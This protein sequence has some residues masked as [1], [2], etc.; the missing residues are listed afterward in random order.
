MESRALETLQTILGRRG[1][2]TNVTHIGDH[3]YT[4]GDQTVLFLEGANPSKTAI[5]KTLE[6]H[7]KNFILVL[8]AP[9]S[10]SI[11]AHMRT[12]ASEPI[13]LF[14]LE[15]LQFDIMSHKKY[16]FPCRIL[17]PDQKANL[18]QTLR[19]TGYRQI[20]RI[21]YDDPYA[22]YLGAKPE[23]VIE[24]DIPSEAAG[25]SKS[26]SYVVTNIEEV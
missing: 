15:Q 25:W 8:S 11:R 14:H 5:D 23:D 3:T 19:I 16:G 10:E 2:Q 9:P 22:L 26:Y 7:P 21:G 1:L 6:E 13:Q 18:M 12:R 17:P 24:F 4:I 20:H